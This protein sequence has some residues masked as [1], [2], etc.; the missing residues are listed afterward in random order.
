M[1]RHRRTAPAIAACAAGLT[2]AACNAGITS[3]KPPATARPAPATPAHT[4]AQS[5]ASAAAS[6]SASS[7]ATATAQGNTVQV[8][9]L[10]S[11]PIPPGAKTTS[12]AVCSKFTIIELGSVTPA[13]ASAF[14]TSALPAAGYKVSL[15]TLS[16][17]P[18][19]GAV[20]DFMFNGHGYAGSIATAASLDT[21]TPSAHASAGAPGGDDKNF[22]EILLERGSTLTDPGGS[23]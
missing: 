11:F 15:D 13:Q 6:S 10:G 5:P 14:Y 7:S 20:S 8:T 4:A 17:D 19:T 22:E 2:L 18:A 12:V 9:G 16:T 21:G 1:H 3:V 23:C